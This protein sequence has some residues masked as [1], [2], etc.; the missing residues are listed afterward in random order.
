M[1]WAFGAGL[2]SRS[3]HGDLG[4]RR[5][6]RF[7]KS[8]SLV[9]RSPRGNPNPSP[10]TEPRSGDRSIAWGVS[11]RDRGDN[12]TKPRS[13]DRQSIADSCG[14][15]RG[16]QSVAPSGLAGLCGLHSWGSR[17]RLIICRAF[18]AERDDASENTRRDVIASRRPRASSPTST[19]GDTGPPGI[20]GTAL[21]A[22]VRTGWPPRPRIRG[23]SPPP[24][25]RGL[26]RKAG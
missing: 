16:Q 20:R 13:G 10:V 24:R 26:H 18:G 8:T 25:R 1:T 22:R 7:T 5:W 21:R 3:H 9:A 19:A 4:L 17:P 12:K 6:P 11:P 2:D 23:G 14:S 15:R